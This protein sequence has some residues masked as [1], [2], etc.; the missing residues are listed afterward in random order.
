MVALARNGEHN[1]FYVLKIM[2]CQATGEASRASNEI[3]DRFLCSWCI[4]TWHSYF[5]LMPLVPRWPLRFSSFYSLF[6]MASNYCVHGLFWIWT[7]SASACS[8]AISD[9]ILPFTLVFP[10]VVCVCGDFFFLAG[11]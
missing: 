11:K 2:D 7:T 8:T 10:W 5:S 1:F 4:Y 3:G 6:V 9:M